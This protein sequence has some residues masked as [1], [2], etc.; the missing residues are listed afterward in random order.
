[1]LLHVT[2]EISDVMRERHRWDSSRWAWRIERQECSPSVNTVSLRNAVATLWSLKSISATQSLYP[3]RQREE[4]Q[5]RTIHSSNTVTISHR[6]SDTAAPVSISQRGR[7]AYTET[8]TQ[9]RSGVWLSCN[10]QNI[11]QENRSSFTVII[12]DY[13]NTDCLGFT[14]ALE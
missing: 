3:N 11:I 4:K 2:E 7:P 10:I 14:A 9:R 6:V 12:G 13:S 8:F 1:V 5:R